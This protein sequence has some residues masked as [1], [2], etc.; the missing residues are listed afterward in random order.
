MKRTV[1]QK[2][3]RRDVAAIYL[4][5]QLRFYPLRLGL[6]DWHSEPRLWRRDRVELATDGRC[7]LVRKAGPD[8]ARID[9][10]GAVLPPQV[11]RGDRRRLRNEPNDRKPRALDALNLEPVLALARP[12]ARDARSPT[13][14][15][16]AIVR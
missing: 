13:L 11:Q 4:G 9:Q 3:V 6:A 16:V 10:R 8:L 7:C 5:P 15:A 1:P 12:I 2:P 14:R